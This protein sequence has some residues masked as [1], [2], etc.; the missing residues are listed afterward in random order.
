MPAER[1]RR[2]RGLF[3]RQNVQLQCDIDKLG[4]DK[5]KRLL[6]YSRRGEFAIVLLAALNDFSPRAGSKREVLQQIGKCGYLNLSAD[7]LRSYD[8]NSEPIWQTEIAYARRDAVN[9]GWMKRMVQQDVW[10]V[11]DEGLAAL[12]RTE[13]RVLSGQYDIARSKYWSPTFFERMKTS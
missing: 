1:S 12:A 8:S 5:M 13:E 7:L 10:E 6:M 2:I 11:S 3:S 9:K 4:N